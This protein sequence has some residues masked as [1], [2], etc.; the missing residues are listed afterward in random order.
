M[1]NHFTAAALILPLAVY[2][3]FNFPTSLPTI[4]SCLFIVV[5]LMYVKW[6]LTMASIWMT[7]I[8]ILEKNLSSGTWYVT[9]T[10][11]VSFL[12]EGS[13]AIQLHLMLQDYH[14]LDIIGLCI[15]AHCVWLDSVSCGKSL[16]SCP[17]LWAWPRYIV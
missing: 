3:S 7:A 16:C 5:I 6:Y 4:I 11:K 15:P 13:K 2:E 12:T 9:T 10:D 14:S 17:W 8:A 1:P